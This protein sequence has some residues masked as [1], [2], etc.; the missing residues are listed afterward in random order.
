MS[1][2]RSSRSIGSGLLASYSVYHWLI[3]FSR[4][5]RQTG[6][7]QT[8]PYATQNARKTGFTQTRPYMLL[9]CLHKG[10]WTIALLAYCTFAGKMTNHQ[11]PKF[12]IS[13]GCHCRNTNALNAFGVKALWKHVKSQPIASRSFSYKQIMGCYHAFEK[14][15]VA[16]ISDHSRLFLFS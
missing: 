7:T 9:L 11:T 2:L 3:S 13:S 14:R 12:L 6:F 8:L 15:E 1:R 16:P 5:A 10:K 4:N